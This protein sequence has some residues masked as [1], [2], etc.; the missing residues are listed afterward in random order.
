MTSQIILPLASAPKSRSL[1]DGPVK[2]TKRKIETVANVEEPKA[3]RAKV[4]T[5]VE[6][7]EPA[8]ESK[9]PAKG[10][11]VYKSDCKCSNCT[12]MRNHLE[13]TGKAALAKFEAIAKF[14]AKAKAKE[15]ASRTVAKPKSK[16]K[17]KPKLIKKTAVKRVPKIKTEADCV[18]DHVRALFAKHNVSGWK[19]F[20]ADSSTLMHSLISHSRHEYT[21]CN[22]RLAAPLEVVLGLALHDICHI[23]TGTSGCDHNDAWTTCSKVINK[24]FKIGKDK[25]VDLEIED[26]CQT[27]KLK[28]AGELRNKVLSG[29][30]AEQ[31]RETKTK[32][33]TKVKADLK[34]IKFNKTDGMPRVVKDAGSGVVL[35]G[36]LPLTARDKALGTHRSFSFDEIVLEGEFQESDV[37]D[38]QR[39][40]FYEESVGVLCEAEIKAGCHVCHV[41]GSDLEV[42]DY[43]EPKDCEYDEDFGFSR[44]RQFSAFCSVNTCG[45]QVVFHDNQT[46]RKMHKE[47]HDDIRRELRELQARKAP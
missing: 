20:R 28:M 45:T 26:L 46:W 8:K 35:S 16:P 1:F 7:K 40:D 5:K 36:K 31:A 14:D 43:S 27:A 22:E 39:P 6:S 17:S 18:L 25:M 38:C 24:E 4:E 29:V 2:P 21:I 33:E 10:C 11:R 30:L 23:K 34:E 37:L 19:I 47:R 15:A 32:V 44:P 3:K 12:S 9:E 13:E 42:F 41:C